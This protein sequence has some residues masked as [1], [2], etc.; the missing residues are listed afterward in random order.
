MTLEGRD[1]FTNPFVL[2]VHLCQC[3]CWA[4]RTQVNQAHLCSHRTHGQAEEKGKMRQ[5]E[6]TTCLGVLVFTKRLLWARPSEEN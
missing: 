1:L 5:E 2:F 3:L 4:L 6:A